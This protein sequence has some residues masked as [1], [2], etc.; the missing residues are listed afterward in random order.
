MP[1]REVHVPSERSASKSDEQSA[2]ALGVPAQPIGLYISAVATTQIAFLEFMSQCTLAW[3]NA[4]T[5]YPTTG[6]PEKE[7][8]LEPKHS[9]VRARRGNRAVTISG[10]EWLSM[11]VITGIEETLSDQFIKPRPVGPPAGPEESEVLAL[12]ERSNEF[13]GIHLVDSTQLADG[14]RDIA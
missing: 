2:T 13:G 4:S 14:H 8:A 1:C 11:P 3:I 6:A 10:S 5:G 9:R 12:W 7:D